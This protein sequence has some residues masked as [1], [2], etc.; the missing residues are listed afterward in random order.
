MKFIKILL[1]QI[2]SLFLLLTISLHSLETVNAAV[3]GDDYPIAWKSGWGTDT[4]GMY[5]RQCTS[6][7][8]FRLNQ[9]NGFSIPSGLGNAD[10]WGHIA[11]R[12]GY[13]VNDIPAVGAVAWFDKGI[14]GSHLAYGHVSW[15]AE[16]NG[17]LVTL[18]EYNFDAGQGP[19][20]YH[21][22]V[23]NSHQVSGFIHFKDVDTGSIPISS[24]IQSPRSTIPNQGSYH[25][26]EQMPIK[27]QPIA[28]NQAI[29]FYQAGQMV[30]Y[31]KTVIADGYQWLSYIAYSGQRRYI[32][33]AKVTSKES[34]KQEDFAPG[35]QVTFSGIYQVTQIHGSLL[36]SKDLAGGEPGPLNWL[37]PGPVLESNRDG[38]QS[39]DQILYPGDFFIIPGNYKV[40]QIHK[41]T[42]GL[43]I[44]IGNRQTWVSMN[45]VQKST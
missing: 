32:P 3:L 35:D 22:R 13:P 24:P 2:V 6:F 45:K 27:A 37:D 21:R 29:A 30:H 7:V 12:M 39:G 25:F 38:Q 17:N 42:K 33:I 40:L 26:T 10:T 41:E 18:E 44:Q 28:N 5:R 4:W 19:E 8:A 23:I 31:D 15:V 1:S 43:L 9:V 14:N 20:Q 11:R 16:V 36:S 34:S